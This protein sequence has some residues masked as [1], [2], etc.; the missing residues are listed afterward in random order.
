M[1]YLL[2][3]LLLV[4]YFFQSANAGVLRY[5]CD[6]ADVDSSETICTVNLGYKYN[7]CTY[8][9]TVGTAALTDFDIALE[10]EAKG[11]VTEYTASADYT[12]PDGYLYY[13]SGD[14]T[15]AGTSGTHALIL[16]HLSTIKK[17]RFTAAGT[18][19]VVEGDIVCND[20]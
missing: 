6:N 3:L 12:S 20:I 19:S 14:L 1:R 2:L 5:A 10:T 7:Q 13:A 16:D 15:T 18:S 4:G 8:T 11:Y 17:V 9:F